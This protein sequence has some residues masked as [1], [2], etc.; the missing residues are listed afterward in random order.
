LGLELK[1]E[2]IERR[3]AGFESLNE[4]ALKQ[5]L[6]KLNIGEDIRGDESALTT[7]ACD[8]SVPVHS[9]RKNESR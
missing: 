7:P 5:Q 6:T 3:R 8:E 2:S 1:L 9:W 4:E